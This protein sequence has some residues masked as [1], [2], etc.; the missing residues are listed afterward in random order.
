MIALKRAL[1]D[2]YL[3][4]SFSGVR[5]RFGDSAEI[6][7]DKQA[8]SSAYGY[9][10]GRSLKGAAG[11]VILARDPR[12]S[13]RALTQALVRGLIASGAPEIVDLGIITT[14]LA[15]SAVRSFSAAGGII[16]TGSHNP[17]CDNGWKF[18]TPAR[19]RRAGSAPEGALLAA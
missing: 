12:R 1:D 10:Y 6:D 3:V 14:P 19:A 2:P 8:L 11:P 7:A 15:Q 13:G 17:L 4:Q 18:L 16:V 5:T 9:Q